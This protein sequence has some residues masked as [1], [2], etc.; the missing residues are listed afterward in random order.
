MVHGVV[1]HERFVLEL[2]PSDVA[3]RSTAELQLG[4][5][6]SEHDAT[7]PPSPPLAAA[8]R[9]RSSPATPALAAA[10]CC[11]TSSCRGGVVESVGR[12][13]RGALLVRHARAA[14]L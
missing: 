6:S 8:Q 9:P 1:T 12:L 5:S 13:L 10:R 7:R 4:S 3:L 11:R 14:K 2:Q